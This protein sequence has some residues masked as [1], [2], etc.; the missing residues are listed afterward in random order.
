MIL[1]EYVSYEFYLPEYGNESVELVLEYKVTIFEELPKR[2]PS[3]FNVEHFCITEAILH[4]S[5]GK[6]ALDLTKVWE[7][8]PNDLKFRFEDE[9]RD[10]ALYN[11]FQFNNERKTERG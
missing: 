8:I 3:D 10:S 6:I 2:N 1:N 4:T 7:L 11:A 9:V 5:K